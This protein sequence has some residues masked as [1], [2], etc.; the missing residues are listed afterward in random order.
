[1]ASIMDRGTVTTTLGYFRT[2]L[3]AAG[4][5][6]HYCIELRDIA[7]RCSE[8]DAKV[9]LAI[10]EHVNEATR[11]RHEEF[12]KAKEIVEGGIAFTKGTND[13]EI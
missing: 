8:K 2:L 9:L 4:A 3:S 6:P 5:A 10:V 12:E 11:R 1:M 7:T 13:N